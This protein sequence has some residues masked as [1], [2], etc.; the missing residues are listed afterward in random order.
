MDQDINNFLAKCEKCQKTKKY[1]HETKNE[2]TPLPQC[3]EPNQRVHMDM[4]GP[5]KTSESGKKYI[6]C[7]TDAF[8]TFAELIALSDKQAP[9]VAEA[10]FSRWLCR[11]GLPLEI[12]QIKAKNFAMRWWMIC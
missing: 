2:L 5:L 11:H 9:K 8:S 1:K 4:F 7:I 12:F 6:M 3:S 10:L